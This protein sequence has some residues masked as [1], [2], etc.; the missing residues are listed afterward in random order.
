MP[1]KKIKKTDVNRIVIAIR[2]KRV[3][4]FMEGH[5]RVLVA[6]GESF[7]TDWTLDQIVSALNG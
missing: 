6:E 4:A 7:K 3:Y 2:Q 5:G 1:N